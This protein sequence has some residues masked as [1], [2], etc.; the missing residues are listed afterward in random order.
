[1]GSRGKM[2]ESADDE[3]RGATDMELWAGEKKK[4]L[5]FFP[6]LYFEWWR[7]GVIF[8]LGGVKKE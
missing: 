7:K 6:S 3:S 1:M 5:R 4:C 2:G 8:W